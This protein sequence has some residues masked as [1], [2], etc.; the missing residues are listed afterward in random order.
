MNFNNLSWFVSVVEAGSITAA[1]RKSYTSQQAV[2]EQVKRLEAHFQLPL[3][4]RTAPLTLTPAGELVYQT[5]KEVL[6]DM[7]R[8]EQQISQLREP[9]IEKLVISTGM[10]GIPPF[11]PRLIAAF[12]KARPACTVSVIQPSSNDNELTSIP[13]QAD[14]LIG[15]LPFDSSLTAMELM[16]DEVCIVA[17]K[18]LLAETYGDSWVR[19]DDALRQGRGYDALDALPFVI[20]Q[21]QEWLREVLYYVNFPFLFPPCAEAVSG[22]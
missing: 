6:A 3:F 17:A 11:L 21:G 10:A 18:S 8:L 14:L 20:Q 5:A 16:K 4:N 15:N 19:T 22:L 9:S 2:S 7:N 13:A 12:R 1:A